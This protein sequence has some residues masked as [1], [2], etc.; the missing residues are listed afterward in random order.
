MAF[1]CYSKIIFQISMYDCGLNFDDI[2]EHSLDRE[3]SEGTVRQVNDASQ[4]EKQDSKSET[5]SLANRPRLDMSS[6][7]M[8]KFLTRLSKIP[9]TKNIYARELM[10]AYLLDEPRELFPRIRA[11]FWSNP[12]QALVER[13]RYIDIERRDKKFIDPPLVEAAKHDD[14]KSVK[15]LIS[16]IGE[17]IST[18]KSIGNDL[19]C[20]HRTAQFTE[21]TKMA[22][23]I[24]N[25]CDDD[26]RAINFLNQRDRTGSTAL[27][28]AAAYNRPAMVAFLLSKGA[29]TDVQNFEWQGETPLD[30]A[31][32]SGNHECYKLLLEAQ[33]ASDAS[34]AQ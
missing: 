5:L 23:H 4:R 21:N 15:V 9:G 1:V 22:N 31:K 24:I 2:G 12:S 7:N 3:I 33:Q 11:T 6:S 17:D 30:C 28:Y 18:I 20:L 19:T 27:H 8:N 25:T 10:D 34:F 16:G 26:S 13:E 32:R 29:R 14:F